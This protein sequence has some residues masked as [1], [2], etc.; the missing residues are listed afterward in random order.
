MFI[1]SK[2]IPELFIYSKDVTK[3]WVSKENKLKS[4]YYSQNILIHMLRT[5]GARSS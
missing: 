4:I 5:K 2:G 1:F 3:L